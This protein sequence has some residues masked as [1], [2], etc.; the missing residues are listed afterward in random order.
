MGWPGPPWLVLGLLLVMH[1]TRPSQALSV[2]KDSAGVRGRREEDEGGEKN[3][4]ERERERERER[5]KLHN[6]DDKLVLQF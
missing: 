1:L 2:V 3:W 5:C 6:G 4:R